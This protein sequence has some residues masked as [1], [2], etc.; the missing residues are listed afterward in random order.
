MQ[1]NVRL[2]GEKFVC[3]DKSSVLGKCDLNVATLQVVVADK[4]GADLSCNENNN[5]KTLSGAFIIV[6]TI[7]ILFSDPSYFYRPLIFIFGRNRA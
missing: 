1:K 5:N 6:I 3:L 7:T 2:L 4:G